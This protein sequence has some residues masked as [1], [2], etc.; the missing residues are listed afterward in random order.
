[1]RHRARG[2]NPGS[3]AQSFCCYPLWSPPHWPGLTLAPCGKE[4]EDQRGMASINNFKSIRGEFFHIQLNT[5]QQELPERRQE[6]KVIFSGRPE[7]PLRGTAN[8]PLCISEHKHSR[9]LACTTSYRGHQLL[10]PLLIRRH[11]G[12]RGRAGTEKKLRQRCLQPGPGLP[13]EVPPCVSTGFL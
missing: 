10:L 3:L 7:R 12:A 13:S 4:S 6:R 2:S 11:Q 1:M 5:R 9:P 8:P